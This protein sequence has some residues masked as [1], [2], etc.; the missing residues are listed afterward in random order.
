[1]KVV[2][3]VVMKNDNG[4]WKAYVWGQPDNHISDWRGTNYRRMAIPGQPQRGYDTEEQAT[5][6]VQDR[7][8]LWDEVE[9]FAN[10]RGDGSYCDYDAFEVRDVGLL[11]RKEKDALHSAS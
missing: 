6:F 3:L 8:S 7:F 5:A 4:R 11:R 10:R 1:M 9:E 2:G